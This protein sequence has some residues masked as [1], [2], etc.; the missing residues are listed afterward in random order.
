VLSYNHKEDGMTVYVTGDLNG[1]NDIGKLSSKKFPQGETL[2]K[3]DVLLIA[4]DFGLVWN[5]TQESK[6][7]TYWLDWIDSKPWI[8]CF[9]DGN[10]ENFPRL[11]AMPTA[12]KFG[13]E[14]GVIRPNIFHLRRG[15]IYTIDEK[16]FFVFGGA[17]SI[18]KDQRIFGISYW[19]EEIPSREEFDKGWDAL[20]NA[21]WKVDYVLSH[22]SPVSSMPSFFGTKITDPT[23]HMLE[24][25]K[26]KLSYLRWYCG[27]LHLDRN[28]PDGVLTLYMKIAKVI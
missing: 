4:G 11:N 7:E 2:T 3:N 14:V 15:N 24:A 12:Q 1:H 20:E 21:N 5:H 13:A 19:P 28:L 22:T 6:Q 17:E 25:Y 23:A 27:H 18:D 9:C 26:Q 8:T 16:S 10:H